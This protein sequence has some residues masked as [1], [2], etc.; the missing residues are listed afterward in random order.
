MEDFNKVTKADMGL[1][2]KLFS[3]TCPDEIPLQFAYGGKQIKGIPGEFRPK[4]S[5]RI[6][7]C[8]L[9]QTLITGEDEKGLEIRAEYLEYRDFPVTELVCYFT[10][11]GKSNTEILSR[12]Q[13][14]GKLNGTKPVFTHG[15]GDT[16]NPEGYEFFS[17]MISQKITLSPSDGTSCNGAFPYMRLM[18]EEYGINIAIGW[19]ARWEVSVSPEESGV[20]FAAGQQRL[21]TYLKPGETIRTPRINLMGFTG[22]ESKGRNMWR[23]WYFKHILPRENG[24]PLSPNLCLHTWMIRQFDAA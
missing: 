2:P 21:N 24:S 18:F 20:V 6:L 12:I 5:R 13:I 14:A 7:D 10:N 9:V 23:R 1:I 8:N 19:P 11:N 3:F 22:G 16:C 15:N 17:D 4:V